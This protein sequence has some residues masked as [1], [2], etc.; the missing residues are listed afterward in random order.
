M[1]R[2]CQWD[3]VRHMDEDNKMD[4]KE[5]LCHRIHFHLCLSASTRYKSVYNKTSTYTH[6]HVFL[7]CCTLQ[8][9]NNI[10]DNN[11]SEWI[12]FEVYCHKL[13]KAWVTENT[14]LPAVWNLSVF[15]SSAAMVFSL[16][17]KSLLSTEE[18]CEEIT[19]MWTDFDKSETGW[20]C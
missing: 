14:F 5:K 20:H 6:L 11:L 18:L 13:F 8:E 9:E 19:F 16:I 3:R 17:Q 7:S 4:R 10:V 1:E 15:T 12:I 2:K